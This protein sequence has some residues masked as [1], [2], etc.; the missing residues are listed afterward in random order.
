MRI[1]Q[2]PG[3]ATSLMN[4]SGVIRSGDGWKSNGQ[5]HRTNIPWLAHASRHLREEEEDD[6]P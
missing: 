2:L 3:F 5:G 4:D 6:S 1:S